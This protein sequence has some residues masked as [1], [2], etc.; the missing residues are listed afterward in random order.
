MDGNLTVQQLLGMA[1][2]VASGMKY[3]SGMNYVHRVCITTINLLNDWNSM[4]I[5]LFVFLI[6]F[7]LFNFT[8]AGPCCA[9]C[10]GVG[11]YGVQSG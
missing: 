11:R 8:L 9:E 3:L 7:Y 1:R 2:G 4:F 5:C 10:F 6:C